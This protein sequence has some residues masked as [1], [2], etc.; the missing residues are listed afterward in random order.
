MKNLLLSLLSLLVLQNICFAR[1]IIEFNFTNDGW[2][3]VS[4]PDGVETKKCFVPHNQTSENYTEMLV[5]YE[6]VLQNKDIAAMSI[7]HKQLGKDRT[8]FVDIEPEYIKQD[9]DD[10]MLT[11]CSKLKG[12]CVVQ[13]AFHGND[14]VIIVSYIN[15]MPHYSQN[16]FGQWSNILSTIKLYNP[17]KPDGLKAN[18]IQL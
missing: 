17:Q 5:F 9:F 18:T 6:R 2:H 7:M 12:T 8:N 10:A 1:D 11:W 13:R 16:M 15:K 4:S 3:Q 14:G